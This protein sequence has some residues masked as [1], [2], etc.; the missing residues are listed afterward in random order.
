MRQANFDAYAAVAEDALRGCTLALS[1]SGVMP[2]DAKF[3]YYKCQ[4]CQKDVVQGWEYQTIIDGDW[5]DLNIVDR[6]LDCQNGRMSAT[7]RKEIEQNRINR[8]MN[9]YW[10]LYD[11]LE[12]AGF[13]NFEEKN[14]I[15]INA[16][17]DCIRFINEVSQGNKTFKDMKPLNLVFN[18]NPGTGKSHLAT[19]IARTLKARGISVGFCPTELLIRDIQDSF[20]DR[21][22]KQEKQILKEITELDVFVFD[23]IGVENYKMEEVSFVTTKLLNFI[24]ARKGKPTIYTTN[25]N[26]ANLEKAIGYRAY[27]RLT[28]G[29]K[30][31][32][33]YTDDHR[34]TRIVKD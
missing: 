11:D 15:L 7:T 26:T 2:I 17:K 14:S 23:D 19:A 3:K 8:M 25:L 5:T 1:R 29:T 31:I 27:S 32:D 33:M 13:K 20:Q 16:K 9:E 4:G 12:E 6:C 28:E 22:R 21:S 18:G 24:N 34:K 30:F 10:F